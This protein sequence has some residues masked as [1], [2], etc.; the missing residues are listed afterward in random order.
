MTLTLIAY[1]IDAQVGYDN[2][3]VGVGLVSYQ[4][5]RIRFVDYSPAVS[6]NGFVWFSKLPRKLPPATNLVRTF[7]TMSWVAIGVS[8]FLV[9]FFLIIVSLLGSHY[10]IGSRDYVDVFGVPFRMLNAEPFPK[11][12]DQNQHNVASQKFFKPGFTG[13]FVLLLWSVMS[14]VI[15]MAF[16]S[17]IRAM[18][19]SPVYEKTIDSTKDLVLSGT[20]PINGKINGFLQNYL[21]D[22]SN[23]WENK[24]FEIGQT[25][26]ENSMKEVLLQTKVYTEETHALL[27]KFEVVT[28]LVL[29]NPWYK[30][31]TP[32]YFHI[33]KEVVSPYY[34]GWICNK[35]SKWKDDMDMHILSLQQ[36]NT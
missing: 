28:Y 12:F 9:S 33:S 35:I 5:Q 32:P 1:A 25:F 7:D 16:N 4:E 3:D 22:S 18:L 17:N 29:R 15:A 21:R 27:D 24:A 14:M 34:H 30:N 23:V 20:I 36:V 31:K 10:G 13:S 2:C 6:V 11:W 8:M 19:L 26:K